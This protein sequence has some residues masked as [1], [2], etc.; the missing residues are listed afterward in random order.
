VSGNRAASRAAIG[1]PMSPRPR[2]VTCVMPGKLHV[3]SSEWMP[4]S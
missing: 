4:T 3:A 1:D 2:N